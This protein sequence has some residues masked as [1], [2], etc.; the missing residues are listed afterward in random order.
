M[1]SSGTPALWIGFAVTVLVMLA[2]DLGLFHRT[3]HEVKVREAAIWSCVWIGLA[4]VFNVIVYFSFGPQLALEFTTAYLIEK[5]LSVDNI[6]VFLVVFSTF[7]VPTAYHHRVLFW[8]IIGALLMRGVF[9]AAGTALLARF[10][11][12]MYV[13]GAILV[14][15]GIK[16]IA[17][18]GEEVE[19]EKNPAVKLFK[20]LFPITPGYRGAHFFVDEP[21]PQGTRRMAT[22]LLLVLV[23]LEATDLVFAVDSVPAVLAVSNDL[24]I[25]YTSNIF[26]ILGLRALYFVLAGILNKFHLLKYGLSLVL[27]FVGGKMLIADLFKVPIVAS[28]LVISVLIAGAVIASLVFP[29]PTR[30]DIDEKQKEKEKAAGKGDGS[31]DDPPAGSDPPRADLGEPSEPRALAK[32]ASSATDP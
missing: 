10:H 30:L 21:T 22:P 13:F 17:K 11:W 28:L 32:N 31:D 23:S 6:F 2:I 16:L 18:P 27:V 26:A 5:A 8:G 4:L 24:F 1:T 15:S 25:V 29:A 19:P 9:I 3:A 12:V 7:A 20:R 14:V